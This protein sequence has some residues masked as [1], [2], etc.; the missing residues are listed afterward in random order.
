MTTAGAVR[1]MAQTSLRDGSASSVSRVMTVCLSV[2][3]VSSSGDWPETVMVSSSAPISRCRS[4][5]DGRVGVD[6][7][8]FLQRAPESLQR[9]LDGVGVPGTSRVN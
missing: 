6:D 2:C 8:P 5:R 7:D 9:R 3:V 1:A 4:T